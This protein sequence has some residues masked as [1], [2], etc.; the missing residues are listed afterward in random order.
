MKKGDLAFFYHS[1]TKV[2]GVVG[3]M[4][5]VEEAV[6][7]ESAFDEND[8]YYDPK[9]NR[10]SPKWF[11]VKVAFRSKFAEPKT[12]TLD[13]LRAH[14]VPSQPLENMQLFTLSR[15]SVSKVAP[16]EWNFILELAG[17]VEPRPLTFDEPEAIPAAQQTS[18]I[19]AEAAAEQD[20]TPADIVGEAIAEV[21]EGIAEG[22]AEAIGQEVADEIAED[23][24]E[25]LGDE[26]AGEVQ[27]EIAD[28]VA[29]Q[30]EEA[31]AEQVEDVVAEQVKEVIAE[32]VADA[33]EQAAIDE[34]EETIE[35]VEATEAI[36]KF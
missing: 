3:I 33:V 32:E 34:I 15:L 28:E 26:V 16:P 27:A 5:I 18:L 35:A 22:A 11:N 10:D 24:R 13:A 25:E 36:G 19:E 23:I 1:N 12:V 29:E 20:E 17:E 30:V 2:P 8:P 9:S 4:E 31:V 21:V 7:D 14:S 6:V